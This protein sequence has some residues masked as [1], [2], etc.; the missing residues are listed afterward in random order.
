MIPPI[1]SNNTQ[2]QR[3]KSSST[4]RPSSA[5]STLAPPSDS[6]STQAPPVRRFVPAH[7]KAPFLTQPEK[8]RRP[9]S[10]TRNS[11]QTNANQRTSATRRSISQQRRGQ[12]AS[13]ST[14]SI[15][16]IFQPKQNESVSTIEA[17]TSNGKHQEDAMPDP[18]S[19]VVTVEEPVY[20]SN[21]IDEI[22]VPPVPQPIILNRALIK[23]LRRLW[24][25]NQSLRLRLAQALEKQSSA[26]PVFIDRL[27]EQVNLVKILSMIRNYFL[28]IHSAPV[29]DAIRIPNVEVL[30]QLAIKLRAVVLY[31]LENCMF[32]P[33]NETIQSIVLVFFLLHIAA[34]DDFEGTLKRLNTLKCLVKQYHIFFTSNLHILVSVRRS[35]L[36]CLYL[37]LINT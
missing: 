30:L 14:Q 34:F 25:Q 7:M 21:E 23:P 6:S 16:K 13:L 20:V 29:A 2:N 28:Q 10:S 36:S 8:K 17:Q 19:G 22:E 33:T 37:L 3:P 27:K 5:S 26:S 32:N 9:T 12:V 4:V 15:V 31:L 24:K 11:I 1:P 35:F 18:T